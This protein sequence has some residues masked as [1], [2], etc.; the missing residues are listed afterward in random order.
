[1][2]K[3]RAI[4][5]RP[6]EP[7]AEVEIE[8]SLKTYQKIVDGYI[9]F[10]PL[11]GVAQKNI[12]AYCNSDGK[13]LDLPLNRAIFQGTKVTDIVCGNIVL[14]GRKG[15]DSVSLSNDQVEF[16]MNRFGQAQKFVFDETGRRLKEVRILK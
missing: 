7:A 5:L 11:P 2:D 4:I 3:I 10:C 8:N 16:I 14:T 9:E 15:E 6:G 12:I 1:M 13:Y